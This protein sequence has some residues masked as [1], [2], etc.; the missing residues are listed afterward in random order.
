MESLQL[1]PFD[2]LKEGVKLTVP[3]GNRK[4][5]S[6]KAGKGQFIKNWGT[7]AVPAGQ[8]RAGAV[9]WPGCARAQRQGCPLALGVLVE[10]PVLCSGQA[11]KGSRYL[12]G[13]SEGTSENPRFIPGGAACPSPLLGSP[14]T[15]TSVPSP[16]LS[17]SGLP[18]CRGEGEGGKSHTDPPESC[19]GRGRGGGGKLI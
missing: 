6:R 18:P 19:R 5:I 2:S 12:P 11:P 8:Y 7:P 4:R 9:G 13:C 16:S 14:S 3:Q 1:D 15:T 10:P 17:R